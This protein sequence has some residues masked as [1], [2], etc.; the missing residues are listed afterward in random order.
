MY[1]EIVVLKALNFYLLILF[2]KQNWYEKLFC[3]KGAAGRVK[4]P[5]G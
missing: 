2:V 5:V 3:N 4:A 1:L